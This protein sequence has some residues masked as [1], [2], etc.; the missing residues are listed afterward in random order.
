MASSDDT[1]HVLHPPSEDL[2][3]KKTAYDFN[4]LQKEAK[5]P[6]EFVWP[7]GDLVKGS[8]EALD[9]PIID[10]KAIK[11]DE[12]AMASAAELVKKACMKHGLFEVT[13]HGVDPLLIIAAHK[14]FDTIFNLSMSKKLSAGTKTNVY[15]YSSAH[16]ERFS[17]SLPWKETFTF[18]YSHIHESQTQVVDFFKSALGE[19]FQ[20]TGLV[21]QRYCNAMKEITE[22]VLELLA[23]SL[24]A[25]SLYYKKFFEDA[26]T[27]MRCNSY[28][29]CNDF[30][31]TFGIGPH[32]DPTSITI[33]HQD[34]IGGLEIFVDDQWVPVRPRP[35]T[36]IVNIGDTFTALSNG[37]YKSCFH[38]VWCN[39]Q[40]VRRS[41]SF[42]LCPKGDKIVKPPNNLFSKEEERN[43]PDFTWLDF[44]QFTQKHYRV[45][46]DTLQRF[47]SWLRAS[48]PSN[49]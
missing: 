11:N 19:E 37:L 46:G 47:V 24:G 35:H 25:D 18:P 23:I 45:D 34:Q 12:S 28:P 49:L 8:E 48:K 44:Y 33:L 4:L 41:L 27:I 29:P 32:C 20:H 36:F 14:E 26:E 43:Y 13:N 39:T 22:V 7:S 9:A 2:K 21:Y 5:M 6:E 1:A 3:D 10:L 30:K 38:R 40:V 42:F 15:G 17:S 31:L 16:A